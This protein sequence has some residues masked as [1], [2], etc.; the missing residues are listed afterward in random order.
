MKIK[1]ASLILLTVVFCAGT[2]LAQTDPDPDSGSS[3]DP[4]DLSTVPASIPVITQ[5]ISFQMNAQLPQVPAVLPFYRPLTIDPLGLGARENAVRNIF[6]FQGGLI[7]TSSDESGN[8]ESAMYGDTEQRS[9]EIFRSGALFFMKEQLFSEQAAD[10]LNLHGSTASASAH[11]TSQ[12][13]SFLAQLG[14]QRQGLYLK[15]VSF[16]ELEKIENGSTSPQTTLVGAAVHYGLDIEGV[17]AWGPGAKTTVYFDAG[18]VTG[19]Y[20]AMSDFEA[21]GEVDVIA[22]AAVMNAF[23]NV[24]RPQT[25]FRLHSGVVTQAVIEEVKLIYFMEAGNKDQQFIMPHYLISGEF[26]GWNPGPD[27]QN[28][29]QGSTTAAPAP[30]VWVE[31]VPEP[32][33]FLQLVSGLLGLTLLARRRKNAARI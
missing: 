1:I 11:F 18:G 27:P 22:P 21:V 28:P 6:D 4:K 2:I 32:G 8:V 15:N 7:G 23:V 10:L 26:F 20:D 31:P 30:F 19:Y 33:A 24:P 13:D 25:L 9:L 5:G 17:P 3:A 14:M 29:T 16:A 12:A